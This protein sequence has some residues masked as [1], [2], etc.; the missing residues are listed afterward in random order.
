M[1]TRRLIEIAFSLFENK[2]DGRCWHCSFI[3]HKSKLLSIGQNQYNKTHPRIYDYN[4]A[5]HARLH[6]ELAACLQLGLTDCT[7]FT[8][9]NIRINRNGELDNSMYCRGCADLVRSLNFK[10]AYFSNENGDIEE[11]SLSTTSRLKA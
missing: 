9:F 1:N 7:G 8:I 6:A 3:L 2:M 5:P 10:R 11:F 4:Y